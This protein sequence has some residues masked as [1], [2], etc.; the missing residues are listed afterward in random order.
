METEPGQQ[1]NVKLRYKNEIYTTTLSG[2]MIDDLQYKG[3]HSSVI[4]TLTAAEKS[5][6]AVG[7]FKYPLEFMYVE[8]IQQD[9]G[10]QME[11]VQVS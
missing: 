5:G 9:N 3:V 8:Q 6:V 7:K 11:V 10:D 4:P 1:Y 2:F